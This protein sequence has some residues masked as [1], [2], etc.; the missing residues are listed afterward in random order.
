[1]AQGYAVALAHGSAAKERATSEA[2]RRRSS[3]RVPGCGPPWTLAQVTDALGRCGGCIGVDSGLSHIA[4]ALDLPH[5]QIYNFD[6]AWRTGPWPCTRVHGR[7]RCLPNP[8]PSVDAVWQ[9]P[10]L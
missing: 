10:G 5:V 6:T 9:L 7:W 4:T 2:D 1:M 8:I 3:A